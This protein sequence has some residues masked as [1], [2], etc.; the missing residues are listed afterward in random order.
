[1][2]QAGVLEAV[3]RG[4]LFETVHEGVDAYCARD[5]HR[6]PLPRLTGRAPGRGPARARLTRAPTMAAGGQGRDEGGRDAARDRSAGGA[7]WRGD[8]AGG[9]LV[10]GDGP[11]T[12]PRRRRRTTRCSWPAAVRAETGVLKGTTYTRKRSL[13]MS[14]VSAAAA[15]RTSLAL[16]TKGSGKLRT[17]TFRNGIYTPV[18]TDHPPHRLHARGGF[19]RLAAALQPLTGR[20]LSGTLVAGG[21]ATAPRSSCPVGFTSLGVVLRHDLVLRAELPR[22]AAERGP[23]HAVGRRLAQ[24][25]G[26]LRQQR[27]RAGRHERHELHSRY[28]TSGYCGLG[29]RRWAACSARRHATSDNKTYD[30]FTGAASHVMLY[31]DTERLRPACS[32]SCWRVPEPAVCAPNIVTNGWTVITGG[33]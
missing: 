6:R 20:A 2:A 1:M 24:D 25:R 3:D 4:H 23:R 18:E 32:G 30:I 7:G 21:S 17:G 19:V 16:Y 5:G 11:A 27:T 22:G 33:R 9:R 12:R 26:R 10:T 15:T 28:T 13:G 14:G 8:A 31:Y 29:V